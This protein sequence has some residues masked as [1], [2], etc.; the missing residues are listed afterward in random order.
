[1]PLRNRE[2]L[3]FEN[4]SSQETCLC[5]TCMAFSVGRRV[6]SFFMFIKH[7]AAR[8]VFLIYKTNIAAEKSRAVERWKMANKSEEIIAEVK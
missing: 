7:S 2:G 8:R 5:C 3:D 6:T 4:T 1:M